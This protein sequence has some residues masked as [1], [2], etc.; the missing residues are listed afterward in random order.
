MTDQ[1]LQHKREREH[2]WSVLMYNRRVSTFCLS[3]SLS[4]KLVADR[5]QY[6][7]ASSHLRLWN[8]EFERS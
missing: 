1:Q 3:L 4:D 6:T 2:T 7:R 8:S 5:S